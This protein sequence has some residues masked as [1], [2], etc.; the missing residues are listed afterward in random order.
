MPAPSQPKQYILLPVNPWFIGFTLVFSL[1]LN[2]LPVGRADWTLAWPDW[3]AITLVFWNIH[4]PRR[5][6]LSLAWV[7]GLIMDVNNA[8]LLG[9]HALAYSVL[10]Y[11]AISLH[12]RVLWFSLPTQVVHVLPLFLAAQMVV[13]LVRLAVGGAFPG[14]TYFSA[15]L[16]AGALWPLVSYLYLAP[17]RRPADKDENR[18]I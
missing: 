8:S 10:S 17:Q 6:G 18:P 3:V 15:S 12:R 4:Q 11:A 13:L 14:I 16:T 9:E 5:V 1:M 2:L 7:L